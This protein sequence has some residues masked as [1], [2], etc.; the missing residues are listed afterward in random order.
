MI[1]D[2][3]HDLRQALRCTLQGLGFEITECCNGEQAIKEIKH[4]NYDIVLLDINMPGMGGIEACREL[5]RLS[6][7]L[8][9]LMLTVRDNEEDKVKA[10]DAGAD[11]Y[12]TKPFSMPE[13]AARLRAA[14]L[15]IRINAQEKAKTIVIGDIELDPDWRIVRKAYKAVHLTPKEFDLLHYLMER[16]P[17]HHARETFKV[18]LGHRIWAGIRIFAHFHPQFAKKIGG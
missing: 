13:L 2:D 1:T 3:N 9:T 7:R 11:D 18:H 15:R 8:E 16:W 14:L 6:P 10:L 17:A 4:R 5:R 12:I